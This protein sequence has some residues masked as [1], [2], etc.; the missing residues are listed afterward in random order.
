MKID[1]NKKRVLK[2][3]P[4]AYIDTMAGGIRVMNGD[5]FIAEEFYMPITTNV[6]TA[7]KY[8]AL[9]CK[10]AQNFNRTHPMR[11]ELSEF[12]SKYNRINNRK[13]RGRRN[14]K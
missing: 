7:W 12:E 6:D 11:M 8:A 2:E 9:A 1:K 10:T 3:Y 4:D 13:R 5:D 14:V